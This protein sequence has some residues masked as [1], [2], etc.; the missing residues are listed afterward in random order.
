MFLDSVKAK[1]E[2]FRTERWA[3]GNVHSVC[4]DRCDALQLGHFFRMSAKHRLE[5]MS[6]WYQSASTLASI[7]TG[8]PSEACTDQQKLEAPGFENHSWNA[9]LQLVINLGLKELEK[10]LSLSQFPSREMEGE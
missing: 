2:F 4:C 8:I 1:L 3:W 7:F 9:D 5:D 6:T 10:G